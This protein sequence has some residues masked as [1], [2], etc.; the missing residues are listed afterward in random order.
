MSGV[1]V[2]VVGEGITGL[3]AARACA[4]AGLSVATF[5]QELFGGLVTSV[6]ELIDWSSAAG[7]RVSG[8]D[9][10][11]EQFSE[12]AAAGVVSHPVQVIG[13]EAT[14]AGVAVKTGTGN[15]V[16]RAL[17]VACGAARR[18]LGLA[19]ATRFL[20]SGLSHCADCDGPLVEGDDVVVVGGGDAALQEAAVLAQYARTVHLVHRGPALRAR[21]VVRAAFE[22]AFAGRSDALVIHLQST[23]TAIEGDAGI[24][25]VLIAGPD[26][27]AARIEARAVFPCIGLVPNSGWTGLDVDAH[28]A[29]VT[30]PGLAAS[31]PAVFAAG[32]VRAGFGG[33]LV[34]AVEDGETAARS[35][36]AAL[37]AG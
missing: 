16:A 13:I 36:I 28:G 6:N 4:A 11:A 31:R 21:P 5:E 26:G 22:K 14:A 33:R 9:L 18:P 27:E 34:D 15:H 8:C 37:A 29:I 17:I 3:T 12:A 19:E 35:V 10:A 20:G 1:D 23:L 2:I 32:A 30:G 25:A 24:E 7:E